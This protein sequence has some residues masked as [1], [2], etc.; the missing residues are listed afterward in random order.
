MDVKNPYV[1]LRELC[2]TS[3]KGFA[4]KHGFGKMT[5]VYL[6]SGM[7]TRVSERQS[8]ALGKECFEKGVD[9][10]E[11]LREEYGA[12]SLN[13]AYLAW[14][15]EDRRVK[16]PGVL[17]KAAPPFEGDDETSPVG[18]F[19]KNTAGSLQ[20]FCKVLKIPSITMTRYIRGET[21]T[22]PEAFWS[23]LE[24]VKYPHAKALAEAQFTWLEGRAL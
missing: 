8:I 18:Y 15:S 21:S 5:M 17:A 12:G 14:R 10:H 1:R 16:A 4:T 6:E 23:A 22:V 7:Y 3:Q 20:G 13:E 24:D 2:G 11:V 9:A 19:V